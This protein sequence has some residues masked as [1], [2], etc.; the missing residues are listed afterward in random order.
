MS[1]VICAV[2]KPLMPVLVESLRILIGH[3]QCT[4]D[5]A[6]Y[7]AGGNFH[8]PCLSLYTV[9][10]LTF[11]SNDTT[12]PQVATV[13]LCVAFLYDIFWVFLSPYIF[14]ESVM[15]KVATGG[16]ITRDPDFCEKYPTAS[17]CQVRS[18]EEMGYVAIIVSF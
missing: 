9:R 13:L 7:V 15:V 16:D 2:V 14:G 18:P 12:P 4:S 10:A 3:E 6:T 8:S 17:G 11:G 5:E 1:S